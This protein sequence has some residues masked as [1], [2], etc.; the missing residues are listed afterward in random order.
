MTRIQE[1]TPKEAIN[2]LKE[3]HAMDYMGTDDNM[4]DDFDNWLN[5]MD[6]IIVCTV[7]TRFAREESRRT[8]MAM[9]EQVEC[10]NKGCA[11]CKAI[12]KAYKHIT[13][14]NYGE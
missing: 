3:E 14:D 13:G 7:M 10:D 6:E 2:F 1:I 11:G 9:V 8:A 5:D 4:P 12:K